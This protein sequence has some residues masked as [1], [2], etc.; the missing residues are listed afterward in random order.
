MNG[1][2]AKLLRKLGKDDHKSKRLFNDIPENAK[3]TLRK[4]VNDMIND[5]LKNENTMEISENDEV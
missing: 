1:K 3:G 5:F 2:Q 4:N